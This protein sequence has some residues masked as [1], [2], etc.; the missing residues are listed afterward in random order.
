M[1]FIAE[2]EQ[3][4]IELQQYIS[5]ERTTHP[6]IHLVLPIILAGMRLRKCVAS[7]FFMWNGKLY[8]R[9]SLSGWAN[10]GAI[11]TRTFVT[12]K[13]DE[14]IKLAE[15]IGCCHS[16]QFDQGKVGRFFASHAERQLLVDWWELTEG[17]GK[18]FRC[19][20]AIVVCDDCKQFF[21]KIG[22]HLGMQ[23]WINDKRY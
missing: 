14:A 13:I 9:L 20:T 1:L 12:P 11:F 18:V 8:T 6:P 5:T 2:I 19:D 3:K 17:K 10:R 21:S 4:N 23:V 22:A 7:M 16:H 15:D